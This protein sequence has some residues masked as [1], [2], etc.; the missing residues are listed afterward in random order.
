MSRPPN[1]P[2]GHYR[3][4]D[5]KPMRKPSRRT[6]KTLPPSR[7]GYALH[8]THSAKADRRIIEALATLEAHEAW[9]GHWVV[10][11]SDRD[12]GCYVTLPC[13]GSPGSY[14]PCLAL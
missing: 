5:L 10:E 3:P 1:Q 2:R 9:K 8:L 11:Y 13:P 7:S 4:P 14:K 12:G 6:P